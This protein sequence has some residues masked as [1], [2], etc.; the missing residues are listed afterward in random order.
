MM[1]G[2]MLHDELTDGIAAALS[3]QGYAV[4]HVGYRLLPRDGTEQR[5]LPDELLRAAEVFRHVYV[6]V[7]SNLDPEDVEAIKN[8]IASLLRRRRRDVDGFEE[9]EIYLIL[10][11]ADDSVNPRVRLVTREDDEG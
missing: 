4:E 6:T 11:G 8:T 1:A 3:E 9:W 2:S 10:Y 7:S 5:G